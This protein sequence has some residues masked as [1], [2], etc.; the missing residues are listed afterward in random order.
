MNKRMI[1]NTLTAFPALPAAASAK[2]E[3]AKMTF[4][5][6]GYIGVAAGNKGSAATR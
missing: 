6:V 2:K 5:D 1:A 4:C 3:P